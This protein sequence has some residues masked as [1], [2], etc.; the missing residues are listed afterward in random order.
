MKMKILIAAALLAS[1]AFANEAEHKMTTQQSRMAACAHESKGMGTPE[2]NHFMSECLKG[3]TAKADAEAPG[4]EITAKSDGA[5]QQGRMKSCNAD[6][7]K[8]E[9]H[10]DERRAFM[11]T[12]LKGM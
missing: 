11:S 7:A 10:G 9:L 6:A 4:R 5:P 8:K 3:H 1:P 2:R 12:C